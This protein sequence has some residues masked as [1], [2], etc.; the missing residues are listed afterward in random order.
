[1]NQRSSNEKTEWKMLI[2]YKDNKENVLW[3]NAARMGRADHDRSPIQEQT[4]ELARQKPPWKQTVS[5]K[6]PASQYN[7][8]IGSLYSGSKV[9][10]QG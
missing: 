8:S 3:N 5:R 4:N 10:D 2:F 1:M 6:R 7:H 9:N